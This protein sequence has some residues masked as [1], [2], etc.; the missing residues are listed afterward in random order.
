MTDPTTL[1][2]AELDEI[3][4]VRVGRVYPSDSH[5]PTPSVIISASE[6]DALVAMAR[7]TEAAERTIALLKRSLELLTKT[8]AE[9][10]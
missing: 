8:L 7:R 2:A 10:E 9:K 6:R 4:D 5:Q 1:S 3:A